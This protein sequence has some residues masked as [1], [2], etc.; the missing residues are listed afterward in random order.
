MRLQSA[1]LLADGRDR[2]NIRQEGNMI[3]EGEEKSRPEKL[4]GAAP[5]GFEE[6][7][8]PKH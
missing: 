4:K 6:A 2:P 8:P 1:S 7:Q 5:L 3:L